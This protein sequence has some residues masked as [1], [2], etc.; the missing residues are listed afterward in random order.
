MTLFKGVG[1]AMVTPFG[2][3]GNIDYAVL[4]AYIEHLI[5]GGA[6]ALIPFG[7]TGEPATA[8]AEE[9][10][11]ATKFVID[12]AAKRVPV[13]VG[14]GSNSTKTAHEHALT[15]KQ[16]GADGVLV[17]TPYYN[18]CTQ[19]G[20]VEHYKAVAKANVPVL[21]YNVPSRTGVNILPAT[22]AKLAQIDGV[23]GIKEA[24]GNIDQFQATAK[25][26]AQTG[27]DM[28]CGDDGITTTAMLMG[29]KGVISVAAS[30]APALMSELCALCEQGEFKAAQALQFKLND[31]ISA[32]FCEVNPIPVKK[33]MQLLGFEVGAPRLPLTELEPEHTALLISTMKELGL[34]K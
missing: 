19:Q 21:A 13:I 28:Y 9:Y 17:V 1:V 8:T 30:P 34:I 24:C 27:F 11:K 22:V 20:I 18:K 3:D 23:V 14:A 26:C 16:L 12:H 5:A 25:V 7:T 33:A 31:F 29:C 32:L 2:K 10:K 4:D 6:S 15:A